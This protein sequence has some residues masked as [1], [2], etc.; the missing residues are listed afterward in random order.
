MRVHIAAD[1]RDFARRAADILCDVVRQ[2]PD[3]VIGLPS[4]KTPLGLY[5][6]LA[7]R[8]RD[9]EADFGRVTAFAIDELHGVSPDHPAIN[10]TYFRHRLTDEVPLR[11]FHVMDSATADPAL[12]CARFRRLI[13]E[14]GG[15][16]LVVLGI[17]LNG[18]IGFNEPGS[19]FD[20]R[21]QRVRLTNTTRAEYAQLFG[22]VQETPG[23]GLTLGIS[24]LLDAADILLLASGAK[25]ADILAQALE[26]PVTEA[27][28]ASALQEHPSLTVLLDNAAASRLRTT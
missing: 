12:E 11:T 7:R 20:S 8:A 5:A 28:P 17:G 14:A 1:E 6:E 24:D 26:G 19:P 2:R 16:D 15:L 9:G 3:A 4:G 18:H 10:A 25:K 13:D 23:Y 21:A 22:S 27:L